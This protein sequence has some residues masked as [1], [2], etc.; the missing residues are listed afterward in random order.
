MKGSVFSWAIPTWYVAVR[1]RLSTAG[2]LPALSRTVAS[3]LPGV[4][5]YGV[6]SMHQR[7]SG[8][9]APRRAVTVLVLMFALG[10]LSVAAVGLYSV[11]SYLV[12]QRKP[13]FGLRAALG[14]DRARLRGL[15]LR[16]AGWL[17]LLGSVLGIC[18]VVVLGRV[19]SATFYGVQAADPLSLLLVVTILGLITL[20][21]GWLPALRA[22]QVPP[23]EALRDR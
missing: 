12:G 10:A 1:T 22:S 5:I 14:A 20:L 3:V 18:G 21:A 15:V 2:I 23:M 19:F 4:P 16:E 7:L 8:T 9:L 13:E 11:Q 17:L 6:R